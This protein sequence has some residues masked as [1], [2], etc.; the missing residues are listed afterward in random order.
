[1]SDLPASCLRIV[2]ITLDT[3]QKEVGVGELPLGSV[4]WTR[5][6]GSFAILGANRVPWGLGLSMERV[7]G[8]VTETGLIVTV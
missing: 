5:S 8:G 7:D 2:L 6:H 4:G 1:M 3:S